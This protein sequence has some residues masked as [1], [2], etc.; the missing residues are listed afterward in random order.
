MMKPVVT[1]LLL[2]IAVIIAAVCGFMWYQAS[3]EL[4]LYRQSFNENSQIVSDGNKRM[5]DS[6]KKS[7][8]VLAAAVLKYRGRYDSLQ[9]QEKKI[10]YKYKLLRNEIA[11]AHDSAQLSITLR[12]L[13]TYDQLGVVIGD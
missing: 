10:V 11:T 13:S 7:N 4:S 1:Y 2:A 6:L 8:E 9:Q 5:I 3:D 12:L